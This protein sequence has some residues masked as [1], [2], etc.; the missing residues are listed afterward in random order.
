MAK[1]PHGT[2]K[3]IRVAVF[4]SGAEAT[5]AIAA[6]ADIVGAEDLIARVQKGEM[7]FDTVIATP[8]MMSQVEINYFEL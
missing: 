1:L 8:E 5:A 2:G 7:P 4:A 6:G 3:K